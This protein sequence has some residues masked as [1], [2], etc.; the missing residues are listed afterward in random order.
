M[1]STMVLSGPPSSVSTYRGPIHQNPPRGEL[2]RSVQVL[3]YDG[4]LAATAGGLV[5]FA[6]GG[7]SSAG[8]V[9]LQANALEWNS[10]SSQFSDYR[11]LGIRVE[12]VPQ[13]EGTQYATITAGGPFYT[14]TDMDDATAP[15]SY[16][17]L[18]S[19]NTLRFVP[20]NK[21]WYREVAMM[22]RPGEGDI[23]PI[24]QFFTRFQ[25]IK[26]VAS[27]ITA[28][29]ILGRIHVWWRVQFFHRE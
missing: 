15:A 12:F 16:G 27:G 28:S 26:F 13:L 4:Q 11:V 5:A 18:A 19:F 6:V 25:S 17:D 2:E 8:T 7:G 20:N 23:I 3:N 14:A 1:P 21:K 9:T 22:G 24:G 10:F 29:Q